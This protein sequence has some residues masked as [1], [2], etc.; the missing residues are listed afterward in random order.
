MVDT[1]DGKTMFLCGGHMIKGKKRLP[2]HSEAIAEGRRMAKKFRDNLA[3]V[4]G[5]DQLAITEIIDLLKADGYDLTGEYELLRSIN[6]MP[7]IVNGCKKLAFGGWLLANENERKPKD[8]EEVAEILGLD[9]ITLFN[10]QKGAD[11]LD[12]FDIHRKKYMRKRGKAVDIVLLSK[13][14]A[15]ERWAV[16]KYYDLYWEVSGGKKPK[17]GAENSNLRGSVKL[18]IQQFANSALE[19]PVMPRLSD[20]GSRLAARILRQEAENGGMDAVQS[21]G[22]DGL[23]EEKRAM[24]EGGDHEGKSEEVLDGIEDGPCRGEDAE[25]EEAAVIQ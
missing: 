15:G 12:F 16:E 22:E 23:Q 17:I 25:T 11:M 8:Y 1:A 4:T 6:P 7:Q 5:P 2:G 24:D 18:E 9:V 10:W 3:K 20:M 19:R 14:L 13:A 21:Q